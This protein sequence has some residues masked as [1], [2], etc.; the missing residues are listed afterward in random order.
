MTVIFRLKWC[1]RKA[2]DKLF[3]LKKENWPDKI[4]PTSC[5][6]SFGIYLN[7]PM[8]D[9]YGKVFGILKKVTILL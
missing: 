3:G 9:L 4:A 8:I 7:T 1:K 6:F 5:F 2:I